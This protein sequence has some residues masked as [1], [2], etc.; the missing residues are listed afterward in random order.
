MMDIVTRLKTQTWSGFQLL[1]AEAVLEIERLRW[2]CEA[3]DEM[4]AIFLRDAE[5]CP[6]LPLDN[7][8]AW[9]D[10]IVTTIK[11]AGFWQ[12]M[13]SKYTTPNAEIERRACASAPMK[14]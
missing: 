11:N 4:V 14:G 8:D 13:R 7:H 1:A 12:L 10:Y 9:T 6:M 2:Q 3:A 5:K